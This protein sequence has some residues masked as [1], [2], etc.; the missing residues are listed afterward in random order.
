[1]LRFATL[2]L[3]ATLS[4]AALAA[5]PAERVRGTIERADATTLVLKTDDG[6]STTVALTPDTKYAAVL[7][8]SLDQIKEGVFIGTATKGDNPPTALEVVLFP[9]SMRGTG[10]G[11]YPWDEIQDTTAGDGPK[12]KSAMTNG[13]VKA[14]AGGAPKVKSA[15]TNGTVARSAGADG[16]T[17]LT[18]SYGADGSKTIAVPASAPVVT[19]EPADAAILRPGAKAFV[20]AG[21]EDG[22]LSARRVAVGKD[23]LRPP[24]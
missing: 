24:M 4:T 23:G 22:K 21:N 1:M 5:P 12:V 8:A 13:T 7:K 2:A 19:F 10:E 15:M 6:R 17:T 16:T 18:V 20:I 14:A 9:E 11:H 3:A